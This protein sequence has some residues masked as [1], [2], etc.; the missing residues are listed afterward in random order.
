MLLSSNVN[1]KYILPPH[2]F[3]LLKYAGLDSKPIFI[4]RP[5][6]SL[7]IEDLDLGCPSA[8]LSQFHSIDLDGDGDEDL[9]FNGACNPYD[10]VVIFWNNEGKFEK[11][12]D[13]PGQIILIQQDN[14][15]VGAAYIFQD[16]CC[17]NYYNQMH[18]VSF[19]HIIHVASLKWHTNIAIPKDITASNRYGSGGIFRNSAIIDD[20]SHEDPCSDDILVGNRDFEC[21]TP[22]QLLTIQ[23]TSKMVLSAVE[24]SPNRWQL[25]W[26]SKAN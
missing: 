13:A 11:A 16:A 25:G 7:V 26:I 24:Y 21:Q 15:R 4:N 14:H 5:P 20:H 3:E 22:L 9:I 8:N 17:C 19:E 2:I 18:R 1:A 6:S 23:E 12:W 10:H